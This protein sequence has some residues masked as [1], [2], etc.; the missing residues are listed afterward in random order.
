VNRETITV[1]NGICRI[2]SKIVDQGDTIVVEAGG[3]V[4]IE[5]LANEASYV[6]V[7]GDIAP[8]PFEEMLLLLKGAKDKLVKLVYADGVVCTCIIRGVAETRIGKTEW[9]L[10]FSDL[11]RPNQ[12]GQM[13]LNAFIRAWI[14]WA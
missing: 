9:V 13:A 2:N 3:Q 4:N 6:C 1:T 14:L 12:Q 8:M 11:Q 5:A 7:Y 10:W